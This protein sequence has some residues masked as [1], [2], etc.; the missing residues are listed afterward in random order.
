MTVNVNLLSVS[1]Q[2]VITIFLLSMQKH[3]VDGV[4]HDKLQKP[5]KERV[6]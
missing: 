2:E 3:L 6:S 5:L 4:V 1:M